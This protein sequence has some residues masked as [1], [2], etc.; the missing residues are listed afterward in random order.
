MIDS[1]RKLAVAIQFLRLPAVVIGLVSLAVMI[2]I[3]A[4]SKSH[5]EDFYLIPS[6]VG[7][8]WSITT[9]NFLVNFRSVP[10]KTDPAWKF[11]K[12]IK[13]K[14]VR[15]GY[16]IIGVVFIATTLVM[17]FLTYRMIL[18]WLKDYGG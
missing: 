3:F 1:F 13:Q 5:E 16:W 4:T 12:R 7:M 11:V 9:Y 15:T 8:L 10:A 6:V 2:K 17:I 14:A 18:I